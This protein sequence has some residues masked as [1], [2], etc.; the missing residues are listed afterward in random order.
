MIIHVD[1]RPLHSGHAHRGIGMYTRLLTEHLEQLPDITVI[2]SA[3]IPTGAPIPQADVTHYP[4][5]DLFFPTLPFHIF[6]KS[7]VTIH[8]VIPLKFPEKYPVGTRGQL[9]FLRQQLALRTTQAIITDSLSSK[10]DI[11]EH[12]HVPENTV[13]VVPLAAHPELQ[14][15][16]D[17]AIAAVRQAYALPKQ[18]VLYVGDINYNKNIPQLIKAIKFLPESV[19]LVCIGKNFTPQPIPEWQWIET[20]I[21]LSGVAERVHFVTD[22]LHDSVT[23]LAACYSGALAYIQPSLYEGFGLPILEAMQCKTPVISTP[24]SSLPEVGGEHCVYAQPEA[25]S[26]AAAVQT[27]AEW[28]KTKRQQVLKAAAAW[29]NTFSWDR[30]AQ[31]TV[32]VYTSVC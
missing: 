26:I 28:S 7:V 18:Y 29:A 21:A 4:F 19:H 32:A 2:R 30:T 1:T 20:Q 23:D 31:E 5:F 15:Q 17:A 10:A 8:D 6:S 22:L 12:L 11:I 16:N 24:V 27:V 14:P 3:A 25:E 13:F 9:A